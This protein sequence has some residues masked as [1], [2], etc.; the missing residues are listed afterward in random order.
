MRL[1]RR[2]KPFDSDD[3]IFELKHDG[4]RALA[5]VEDGQCR[6]VSRNGHTFTKF[7]DL[8]ANIAATIRS[9]N[10]VLDGEIVCLDATGRSVFN[11]LMFRREGDCYFFAFDVLFADDEDVRDSPLIERKRRLRKLI[12]RKTSRLLYLDHIEGRGCELCAFTDK[13]AAPGSIKWQ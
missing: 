9:E 2:S 8:C 11:D 10:A 4:F 5:Y 13:M 3:W 12:P 1:S 7:A 6:F